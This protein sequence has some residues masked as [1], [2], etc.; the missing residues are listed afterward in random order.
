M[1]S[2]AG[3]M[4]FSRVGAPNMRVAQLGKYTTRSPPFAATFGDAGP[5]RS[6]RETCGIAPPVI[7]RANLASASVAPSPMMV[8]LKAFA[9][10][11]S[12]IERSTARVWRPTRCAVRRSASVR[13]LA[14]SPSTM[15][16]VSMPTGQR[17]AQTLPAAQVARP[18]YSNSF[19]ISAS[20]AG[21]SPDVLSRAFSRVTTMRWRGLNVMW[22]LGQA[23][24]QKPHSMQRSTTGSASGM[25]FRS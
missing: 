3:S 24:S 2:V 8:R 16:P 14:R 17:R 23:G 18:A 4:P 10:T 19:S 1:A 12:F 11:A 15:V 7:P 9:P 20:F 5:G 6:A 22:W 13:R 21:F 25:R